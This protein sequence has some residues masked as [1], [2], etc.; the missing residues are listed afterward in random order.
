MRIF[1]AGGAGAVGRFLVPMLVAAGH[2]VTATTRQQDRTARLESVGAHP[3]LLDMYDADAVHAAVS[4][5]R[6]EVVIDQLTDLSTGFDPASL[7]R[8]ALLRE[9]TTPILVEAAVRAGAHRLIAASGAW[10][11]APGPL[12]H[13]ETDPLR[14]AASDPNDSVVPGIIA[15][16]SAVLSAPLQGVVLRYGYFYGPG[17]STAIADQDPSVHVGAAAR[18]SMLAVGAGMSPIYNV[19]DD[20][21]TVSNALAKHELG[22]R[23]DAVDVSS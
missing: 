8:N 21:P 9:V 23:P 10:L 3:Q 20:G 11:Y 12:P 14:T 2:E 13:A 22:W 1:V 7:R 5:A 15:L 17:T 19:V 18:A 4:V 16:E 6:P